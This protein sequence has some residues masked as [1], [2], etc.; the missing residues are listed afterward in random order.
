MATEDNGQ[1][2][3]I[4][5]PFKYQEV[6]DKFPEESK[7]YYYK[8]TESMYRVV[9]HN[10]ATIDDFTPKAV[11][12]GE[13]GIPKVVLSDYDEDT[14]TDV[15]REILGE[16]GTSHYKKK[17]KLERM[18]RN[19]YKRT[20]KNRGKAGGEAIKQDLGTFIIKI[21]YDKSD[22]K[23]SKIRN[24]SHANVMLFDDVDPLSKIDEEF[25]YPEIKFEEDGE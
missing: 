2:E 13:E 1:D 15:Q 19:A 6:F 18:V 11:K 4:V 7:N 3:A 9:S 8:D 5:R 14:P 25:G 10:P 12:Y 16:Y 17:E 21:K 20:C 24:D 23:M 22:G